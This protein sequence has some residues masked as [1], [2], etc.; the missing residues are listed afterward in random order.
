MSTKNTNPAIEV[1][2]DDS[3]EAWKDFQDSVIAWEDQFATTDVA[4]LQ[5]ETFDNTV[6]APLLDDFD[7]FSSVTKNS[8]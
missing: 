5:T 7:V 4:P 8:P 6:P 1:N 2:E 3:E